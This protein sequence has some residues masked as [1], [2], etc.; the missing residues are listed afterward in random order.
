MATQ[1]QR[2]AIEAIAVLHETIKPGDTLYCTTCHVSRSGMMRKIKIFSASCEKEYEN[3]K[4]IGTRPAVRN[5]SFRV[6]KALGWRF[7]ERWDAIDVHGCGMDMHFH[8]VYTL[9]SALF[10]KGG[11][12]KLSPRRAQEERAGEKI[13]R[14]G[15][16]LLKHRSL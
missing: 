4:P 15:G 8:T 1:K 2:D 5:I 16:Y 6:A 12:L 3:G 11:D 14:D 13:E 10:P 9:G 7:D